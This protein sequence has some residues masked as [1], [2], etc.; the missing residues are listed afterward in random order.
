MKFQRLLEIVGEEPVFHT[1]LLLAGEVA[2]DSLRTQLSRW[3]RTGRLLQLRRG[4][5]SLP[6]PYRKVDPHPFLVANRLVQGSYVSLQSALAHHGLIP[7]EVPTVTSVAT[8]R[9]CSK[10]TPL[11]RYL[12][13]HI[14]RRYLGGYRPE[15][16][17]RGQVALVACP[18]KALLDLIHL[19]PGGQSREYLEELRLQGLDLLDLRQLRTLARTVKRPKLERAVQNLAAIVDRER[20][21]FAPL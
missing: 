13:R 18:E 20:G 12:C 3:V 9:T 17:A 21:E 15:T 8:S 1:G 10:Q 6:P 16:V 14:G 4:L 5:Y 11:G 19:E 2:L 7:E